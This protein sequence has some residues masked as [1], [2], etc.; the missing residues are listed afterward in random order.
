M[1]KSTVDQVVQMT[2]NIEDSFKAKKKAVAVFV[3]LTA[4]YDTVWHRV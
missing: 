3:N 4:P 1:R 2:Q